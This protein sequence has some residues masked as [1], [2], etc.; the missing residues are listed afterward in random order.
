MLKLFSTLPTFTE[1]FDGLPV[2][3]PDGKKLCWTSGRAG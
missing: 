1:G 2:F 3:S